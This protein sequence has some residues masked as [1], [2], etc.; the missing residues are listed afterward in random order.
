MNEPE[1]SLR[2]H[3][4]RQSL[5]PERVAAILAEGRKLAEER[6]RRLRWWRWSGGLAAAAAVTATA[7]LVWTAR[8]PDEGGTPP[9]AITGEGVA[10]SAPAVDGATLQAGIRAFFNDPDYQL[11][12][13]ALDAAEL[14][15]WMQTQGAPSELSVP[16]AVDDLDNL[17]CEILDVD[18]VS[19]YILCF[20][21][22]GV[23]RGEDG[24]P[25][26]GKKLMAVNAPDAPEGAPAM[27]KPLDLVHLVT[28]P[29]DQFVG[30]P[31][32]GD[33]VAVTRDGNWGFATWAGDD[34]VYVAAS[35]ADAERFAALAAQLGQS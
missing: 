24:T 3:Y 34:V 26:L 1:Q 17:G 22:D 16:A 27:M 4:E 31:Q 13:M 10:A 21:L 20:Y 29:R 11:D 15:A 14:V 2:K 25:M 23:P 19:V 5:S 8:S 9:V 18:G 30:A 33:P 7:G 35:P 32:V 28:V 6:E 12:R